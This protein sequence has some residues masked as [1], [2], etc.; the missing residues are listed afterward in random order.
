MPRK[1]YT[2]EQIINSLREAE[3]LISQGS[4]AKEASRHLGI[5]E[6]TYYKWR[7][8]YG[9]MRINQAKRL[10]ELEKENARLKKLVGDISLDNAI[11]KDGAGISQKQMLNFVKKVNPEIVGMTM[12]T[13]NRFEVLDL[14]KKIK[15]MLRVPIILGGPHP[16]LLPEQL[17]KNYGF[18]NYI[19]RNEGEKTI[20][21]LIDAIENKKDLEKIKGISYR[22]KGVVKHNAPVDSIINLDELP[23]PEWKFFDLSKYSKQN[24]YPKEFEKYPVGSIISSRG[25]PFQCTFCSSSSLWGHKIRFR[26]AENVLEEIKMLYNLGI[27][28]FVYNDDNFT[29]D[30]KRAIKICR[31]MVDEGLHKKMGWQCRAEVNL[32]DDEL[33]GWMKKANCNMIEFGVE[34]CSSEGLKWFK[35]GHTHDQVK[36]AFDL[37]KKYRI[38][39]K[40]YFILGGDF[41]TKENIQ[42]KKKYIS[43][44]DP[45]TTTASILLAYP[46]TEIYELGKSK[47]L[48]KDDVWLTKCVGEKFHSCAPIYTGPNLTYQ[49]LF[50]ASA[51]IIYWW[52]K[53]KGQNVLKNSVGIALGMLRKGEIKKLGNLS[54]AVLKQTMK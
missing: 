18:I 44:L 47:G 23:F 46:G 6:Q 21:N 10:K 40:S 51:D 48:W 4:T 5:S 43:D 38:K 27:R 54:F 30:K 22:K 16:S 14:A 19:V 32:M 50:S 11:L 49:D 33:L 28:F 20:V 53:K 15:N 1:R 34:D 9:G 2:P 35:K 3:V 36:I 13:T 52:G 24:E 7:K 17:L 37:C 29:S 41:E 8:E 31:L 45:D 26:S 42:K 39:I 12:N 25:C